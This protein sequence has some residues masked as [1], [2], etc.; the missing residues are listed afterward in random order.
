MCRIVHLLQ[1]KSNPVKKER[2]LTMSPARNIL[3]KEPR[4]DIFPEQNRITVSQIVLHSQNV[5]FIF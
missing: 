2:L 5:L 1:E 4:W 3:S